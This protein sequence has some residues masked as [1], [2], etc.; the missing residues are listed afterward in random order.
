MLLGVAGIFGLVF[1]P[2]LLV[3]GVVTAS[4][5]GSDSTIDHPRF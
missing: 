2:S 1:C 4:V 3:V 5:R